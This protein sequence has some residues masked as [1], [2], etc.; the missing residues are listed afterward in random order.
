MNNLIKIRIKKIIATKALLLLMSLLLAT[1]SSAE[2]KSN[3]DSTGN[4]IR[5]ALKVEDGA[6]DMNKLA[7]RDEILSSG[8][9]KNAIPAES[10]F[11]EQDIPENEAWSKIALEKSR[12]YS[13]LQDFDDYY[14][15]VEPIEERNLEHPLV[16]IWMYDNKRHSACKIFQQ[17]RN[18]STSL[19]IIDLDWTYDIE[20][21]DSAVESDEGGSIKIKVYKAKPILVISAIETCE[22]PHLYYYT[23]IID[24]S[25]NKSKIIEGQK[26]SGIFKPDDTGL[27][28]NEIGLT[29]GLIMTTTTEYKSKYIHSVE[30][31]ISLETVIPYYCCPLKLKMAKTSYPKPCKIGLR[32]YSFKK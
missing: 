18:D 14:F 1:S 26:F 25:T 3:N 13:E 8:I 27:M 15:F 5:F 12:I 9:P 10:Y 29:K 21:V 32:A 16:D 2:I 6:I 24:P 4:R 22:T 23:Y 28:A 31:L 19:N 20:S 17:D 30:P 11:T 7:T